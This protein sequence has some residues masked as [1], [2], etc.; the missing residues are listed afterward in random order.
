MQSFVLLAAIMIF[1]SAHVVSPIIL[2]WTTPELRGIVAREWVKHIVAPAAILAGVL[3]A[4]IA[5]VA[6][7]YWA[8][9]IYHFG[10]QH[11]GV[12]R[13]LGWRVPRWACVV[14][15]AA[16]M[17]GGPLLIHAVWWEWLMLFALNFTHWLTD[18]GLSSRVA[19]WHWGFVALVLAIGAAWLLLRNGPL[20]VRLVPQI[21]VI[22]M[23]LGMVHFIYSA[24]IWKRDA[25]LGMLR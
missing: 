22:R 16:L 9:N 10:A 4:P 25:A 23:G 12:S 21:V 20:A 7:I 8:W 13:L 15:T 6:W 17:A 24:R 2:A 1:E 18:I 19:R 3:V 5:W 11:Y 14:G